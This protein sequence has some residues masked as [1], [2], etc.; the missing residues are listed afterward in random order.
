MG[1]SIQDFA[2]GS[3]VVETGIQEEEVAFFESLN[4]LPNEF[5][6]RSA[7]FV[8]DETQRGA[9]DQIKEAAQLDGDRT[10]TL[11]TAVRTETFPEGMGFG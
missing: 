5:L 2:E 3:A 11:L 1:F 4:Q 9:A 10:Q 7:D 8:V 6:F